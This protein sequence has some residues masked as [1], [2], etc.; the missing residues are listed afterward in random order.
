MRAVCDEAMVHI[1][2]ELPQALI[3][4]ATNDDRVAN[5]INLSIPGLDTEFTAVVLD[6]AGFAISTKS[7]CSGAGGGAS[8]VVLE[9]TTDLARAAST[10]RITLGPDTSLEDIKS[11]TEVLK[12]HVKQMSQY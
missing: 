2:N 1:Q 12:R 11:L 4:G 7:A 5:N 8:T 3:N 10:L 9:T 6:T